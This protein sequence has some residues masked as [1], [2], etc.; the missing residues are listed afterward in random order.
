MKNKSIIFAIL[1]ILSC[2]Q[3]AKR[4]LT[5][6]RSNAITRA[7]R[8]NS[9]SVVGINV[10]SVDVN[11][12]NYNKFWSNFFPY[13]NNNNKIRSFGSG[14]IISSDGYIV[15]NAHVVENSE[16]IIVTLEG[17]L[18]HLA[19][20]IGIDKPT[21]L[22]LLKIE[23][24]DLPHFTFGNSDSII[25]GEW[26][27]AMGNPL[28]LFDISNKA[29]ATAGIVSGLGIDFG[30]RESGQ[31]YQNMIQTDASINQG[32]SGGPL[33]NSNGKI[34]GINTFIMTGNSSG[35]EGSVGIGFAI[36]SNRVVN[37]IE[38]LKKN[39]KINRNYNTGLKVQKLDDALAKY[40]RL[41]VK[42]VL[43]QD[44]EFNS[45]GEEAGL[46]VGDV[47][48]AVNSQNVESPQDIIK[49]ISEGLHRVG[50]YI[51]LVII[52]NNLKKKIKLRLEDPKSKYWGF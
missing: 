10:I 43:V 25:V 48:V 14:A 2:N 21:D 45:A 20:L 3:E 42:G 27:I 4:A 9:L 5:N 51:N 24:N 26:A 15:T 16:E 22:A 52:R 7:I 18:K 6:D 44:V 11:Q 46:K 29:T 38:E 37:V 39:G 35:N 40:L 23:E 50:D 47:I 1:C 28:A 13:Y 31:V 36:P 41:K 34:I 19:K 30:L 32:N 49:V 12:L 8:D 33:I 17:G